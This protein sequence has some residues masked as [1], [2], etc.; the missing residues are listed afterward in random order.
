MERSSRQRTFNADVGL[1][2]AGLGD[3]CTGERQADP[4]EWLAREQKE[5]CSVP[6]SDDLGELGMAGACGEER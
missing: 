1:A 3:I 2:D 4:G 6:T 5:N